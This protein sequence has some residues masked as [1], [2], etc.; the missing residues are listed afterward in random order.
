MNGFCS[1]AHCLRNANKVKGTITLDREKA[2]LMGKWQRLK[3]KL[4]EI[5]GVIILF[6][7][8]HYFGDYFLNIMT[9]QFWIGVILFAFGLF[10][11]SEYAVHISITKKCE[12]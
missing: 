5:L 1:S 11:T 3:W 10:L 12:H 6:Q 7:A 9:W 4:I 2:K 8:A